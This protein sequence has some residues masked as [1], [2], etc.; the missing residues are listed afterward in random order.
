M[1]DVVQLNVS[2]KTERDGT[3]HTIGIDSNDFEYSNSNG[4]V[5]NMSL[6]E[7]E[8][9][10]TLYSNSFLS[11]RI[12]VKGNPKIIISLGPRMMTQLF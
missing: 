2:W 11:H 5:W 6:G 4:L 9:L 12:S 8:H 1:T 3:T 7:I 10:T